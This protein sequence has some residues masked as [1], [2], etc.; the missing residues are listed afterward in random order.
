MDIYSHFGTDEKLE[1][2]GRWVEF[3]DK[4]SFKIARANNKA[5]ARLFTR[6]YERNRIALTSKGE[7]AEKAAEKLMIDTMAKTILVDWKGPVKL[8]GEDLSVYSE[9]NAKLVLAHKE[10]RKWVQAQADDFEA[11]KAVQADEEAKN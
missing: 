10:F 6:E 4:T 11:Y 5:F 1:I 9:D 8:Q 3:D 7:N 2:E